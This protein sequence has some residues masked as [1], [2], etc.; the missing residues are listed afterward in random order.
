M[1]GATSLKLPFCRASFQPVLKSCHMTMSKALAI[2]GQVE[3]GYFYL[4]TFT[5]NANPHI[6]KFFEASKVDIIGN[7]EDEEVEVTIVML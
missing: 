7:S 5:Q 4:M 3:I 6:I 2:I 1:R